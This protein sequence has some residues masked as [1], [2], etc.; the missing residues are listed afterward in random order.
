MDV[1]K[2]KILRV[3]SVLAVAFAVGH[4]VE[5]MK[6]PVPSGSFIAA[7]AT[8]QSPRPV[9]ADSG[10]PL[11]ASMASGLGRSE[12]MAITSVA[13]SVPEASLNDCTASLDL[14]AQPGGILNVLVNAPCHKGERVVIRHAGLNFTARISIDGKAALQFPAL[15]TDAMVTGFLRNSEVVVSSVTVSDAADFQRFALQ[16]TAA[17][18]F[19]LRVSEG[20][21]IY[22]GDRRAR[23]Q[24]GSQTIRSLGDTLVEDPMFAEI[25]SYPRDASTPVDITVEVRVTPQTCGNSLVAET[26]SSSAGKVQINEIPVQIP[27]C[28]A[29]GDILV[30][31]NLAPPTKIAAA[32]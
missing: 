6:K 29:V 3:V 21:R 25:Y 14:A 23:N 15:Q 10:L 17:D 8:A 4:L 24:P 27:A 26:I 16:W 9:L 19:N 7:E 32:N 30:L 22:V 11:S 13:A 12:V 20:D 1:K 2:Q 31:K 5:S 28:D 18:V